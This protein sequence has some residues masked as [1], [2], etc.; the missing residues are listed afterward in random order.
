LSRVSPLPPFPPEV[1]GQ[2]MPLSVPLR[3]SMR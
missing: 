1:S 3:F 2:S